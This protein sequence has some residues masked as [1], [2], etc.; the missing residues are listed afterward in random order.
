MFPPGKNFYKSIDMSDR[1][2]H[3]MFELKEGSTLDNWAF[4][5]NFGKER[6]LEAAL[7]ISGFQRKY[8]EKQ[9]ILFQDMLQNFEV[10]SYADK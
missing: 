9:R 10:I 1:S 3:I 8:V 5:T 2:L 6:V 4:N 7:F